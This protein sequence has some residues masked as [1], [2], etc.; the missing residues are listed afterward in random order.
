M[1]L[2][3]SF[4]YI[5]VFDSLFSY[6]LFRYHFVGPLLLFPPAHH[7]SVCTTGPFVFFHPHVIAVWLATHNAE[8]KQHVSCRTHDAL[9]DTRRKSQ[10]V[11]KTQHR[12]LSAVLSRLRKTVPLTSAHPCQRPRRRPVQRPTRTIPLRPPRVKMRVSAHVKTHEGQGL[13]LSAL[14]LTV[15][16]YQTRLQLCFLI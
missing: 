8:R 7:S 2:P 10:C 11:R 6:I 15:S 5:F 14:C 9:A 16:C 4:L 3:T 13:H 12:L 1:L